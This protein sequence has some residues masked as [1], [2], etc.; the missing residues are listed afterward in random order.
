MMLCFRKALAI[1]IVPKMCWGRFKRYYLNGLF[2]FLLLGPFPNIVTIFKYP[3][4]PY[5]TKE[6]ERNKRATIPKMFTYMFIIRKLTNFSVT[7]R[8]DRDRRKSS[9]AFLGEC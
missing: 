9:L 3:P 1:V 5:A 8:D 7:Y 4:A 6:K 2:Y